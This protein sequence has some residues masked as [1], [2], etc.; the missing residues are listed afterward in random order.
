MSY[1]CENCGEYFDLPLI[2]HESH[3][4]G[5][6]WFEVLEC[7]PLCRVSGMFKESSHA[8]GSY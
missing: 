6:P 5:G 4:L 8:G 7:C 3:G 1:Q 2:V